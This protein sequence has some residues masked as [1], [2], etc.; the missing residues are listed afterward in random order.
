MRART[1]QPY[2]IVDEHE[3]LFNARFL[4]LGGAGSR[5][6]CPCSKLGM[7]EEFQDFFGLRSFEQGQVILS[8]GSS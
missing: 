4:R 3:V 8:T 2:Q 6:R 5:R 1:M 7:V